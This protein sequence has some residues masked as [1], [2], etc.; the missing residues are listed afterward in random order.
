MKYMR[1]IFFPF[2]LSFGVHAFAPVIGMSR[3]L[4]GGESVA[5]DHD[6]GSSVKLSL[7]NNYSRLKPIPSTVLS[8]LDLDEAVRLAEE[9]NPVIQERFHS[10]VAARNQLGSAYA[11][12]WPTLTADLEFGW[13][14]EN[15]YYNYSGALAG[16]TTTD[17]AESTLSSSSGGKKSCSSASSYLYC[18][19]FSSNY[20]QGV[21]T[22][23]LDWTIF[24]PARQPLVDKNQSLV[25]EAKSDYVIARRDYALRTRESFVELQRYLAGV[26]TSSQLVENDRLLSRLAQSR[27]RLGVAS[28][29]DVAKQITVLKTDQ[30][31]QVTAEKN[32]RV[33]KSKLAQ[34]L[35][36]PLAT[37][38]SPSTQLMPLGGWQSSLEETVKAAL[39]YRQVIE[40]QL[41]IVRQ[42][43]QQSRIA[44]ATYFPT[45]SLVN[46]LYWTKGV[47]YTGLGPPWVIESAR[48]DLW[49]AQSVLSV[50]FTGFDGG[51]ARMESEASKARAA[52]AVSAVED[53]INSVISEVREYYARV[54]D[55]RDAVIVASE[56][57][58]AA[59]S[60][61]RL[62]SMRFSAG[63]GTITDVVQSQQDL[64]Q[65]VDVYIQQLGD[66]NL[67]LVNLSRASG[68]DFVSD[69]DLIDK[70]GDPLSQ[71]KIT[72]YLG[73]AD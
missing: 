21:T 49:D 18:K 36:D 54:E 72:G 16:L 39:L 58:N 59:T 10:L 51:K 26:Q 3:D 71:V 46:S 30:V 22:I 48:S 55:G 50:T 25:D 64:T 53:S 13:Y 6:P 60:A 66:Y 15:A 44:L 40:K 31:N 9:R 24:D 32:A 14:G 37:T 12:W 41:A 5:S 8:N 47:G 11:S 27:K 43:E 17:G 29:L 33:A 20:G 61:L 65:S 56:R 28:D 42:N 68:V 57:V 62:Q 69:P 35:N 63:Y 70:V 34:L 1:Y 4:A 38:I 52:A 23:D 45:I 2:L 73:L 7:Q 67:A 19:S